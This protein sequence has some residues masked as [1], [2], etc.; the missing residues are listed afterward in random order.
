MSIMWAILGGL[1]PLAGGVA[2]A[3][4][5]TSRFDDPAQLPPQ[6]RT[7]FLEVVKPAISTQVEL[8]IELLR[9]DA[10]WHKKWDSARDKA[11]WQHETGVS[12][13]RYALSYTKKTFEVTAEIADDNGVY[14]NVD[15][16][17]EEAKCLS[18]EIKAY[19]TR[20]RDRE[21]RALAAALAKRVLEGRTV[22]SVSAGTTGPDAGAEGDRMEWDDLVPAGILT[23]DKRLKQVVT[24]GGDTAAKKL[25]RELAERYDMEAM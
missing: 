5:G 11:F 22:H 20:L 6:T 17:G 14:H 7:D 10:G 21:Q 9:G 18:A 13:K 19:E 16:S 24:L 2:F 1:A 3:Y 15:L 25:S 12:V 4:L 8:I 23:Y